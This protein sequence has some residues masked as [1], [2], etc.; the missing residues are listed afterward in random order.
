MSPEEFAKMEKAQQAVKNWFSGKFEGFESGDRIPDMDMQELYD[1]ID[2]FFGDKSDFS[3]TAKEVFR[4][5]FPEG[6]PADYKQQMAERIHELV[7]ITPGDF[8]QALLGIQIKLATDEEFTAWTMGQFQGKIGRQIEWMMGEIIVGG[9]LAG[10]EYSVPEDMS[11]FANPLTKSATQESSMSAQ[12]P[13]GT[14]SQTE[15]SDV[16]PIPSNKNGDLQ[17]AAGSGTPAALPPARIIGIRE[18]LSL[19]GTK[20]G[21]LH[22]LKTDKE[23]ANWLLKQFGTPAKI[24]AWLSEQGTKTPSRKVPTPPVLPQT[25]P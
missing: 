23:A 17:V 25:Q 12:K 19:H 4:M 3:E 20:A 10:I 16:P 13:Q 1:I 24:D 15:T 2:P 21:M 9:Q 22:L 8:G 11:K 5:Q 7:A 14:A 6:E 18:T